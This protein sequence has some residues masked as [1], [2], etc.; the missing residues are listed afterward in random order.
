MTPAVPTFLSFD[1]EPD[2]FQA[3]GDDGWRGASAF[4]EFVPR[5]RERLADA[6]GTNPVFGWYL[7]MDP[8]VATMFGD[9]TASVHAVEPGLRDGIAHGDGIGL[10]VHPIRW[11]ADTGDW[12][13]DVTDPAWTVDCVEES[14]SAFTGCFGEAPRRYR[15]GAGVLNN[16]VIATIDRLGV[17][18]DLSLEPE[19]G[20]ALQ[21]DYVNSGIDR[22]RLLGKGADCGPAPLEIYRPSVADFRVR[23]RRSARSMVMVPHSATRLDRT[24]GVRR[25]V[26]RRLREPL[27]RPPAYVLFPSVAWPSERPADFWDLVERQLA[28]MQRP[29]VALAF[30]S[31]APDSVVS[32][33]ALGVLDAL[34]DH[35]IARRLQFVD[36]LVAAA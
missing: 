29:H 26:R 20:W 14:V 24:D 35:P 11:S 21:S 1:V 13:H 22:S 36:P 9:A 8:Q 32:R 25:R 10:H 12:V 34:P 2:G 5:L 18:V 17:R 28:T 23:G 15:H 7:R 3:P 27:R 16:D 4:T 6:T 19:R 31:D 30:R 33:R